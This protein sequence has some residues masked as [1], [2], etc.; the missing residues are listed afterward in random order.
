M[1]CNCGYVDYHIPSCPQWRQIPQS[2][3]STTYT[4]TQCPDFDP[5]EEKITSDCV[6][7]MGEDLECFGIYNGDSATTIIGHILE[8]LLPNCTTTSTTTSTTTTTTIDPA[9][10]HCITFTNVCNYNTNGTGARYT[11]CNGV[12]QVIKDGPGLNMVP[13]ETITVCGSNPQVGNSC[14]AFYVEG[15]PCDL[16]P[17]GVYFCGTLPTT[18]TSTSTTT[19]APCLCYTYA[20]ANIDPKASHTFTYLSCSTKIQTA[21][22]LSAAGTIGDKVSVCVCNEDISAPKGFFTVTPIGKDCITSTST[23]TTTTAAVTPTPC[24]NYTIIAP[25]NTAGTYSYV[26]CLLNITITGEITNNNPGAVDCVYIRAAVAGSVFV[27]VGSGLV[28][29]PG[30][31]CPT[32]TTTTPVCATFSLFNTDTNS[33]TYAYLDCVGGDVSGTLAAGQCISFRALTGSITYEVGIQFFN[34]NVCPTT[35]TTSTSTTTT[36]LALTP[37]FLS[38]MTAT[39][40]FSSILMGVGELG[41]P[42]AYPVP[43]NVLLTSYYT[44]TY[45]IKVTLTNVQAGTTIKVTD[46]NG[47]IQSYTFA[48]SGG[49]LY[50]TFNGVVLNGIT[51]MKIEISI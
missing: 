9:L 23:T 39:S 16:K 3:T 19:E 47:I 14:F 10:C 44:G 29:A 25:G 6:V 50:R 1:S 35:T 18:T 40:N 30:D 45:N 32:T 2:T 41:N 43:D 36:T 4:T 26:D 17:G 38:N 51:Q 46:S 49:G 27:Q 24:S 15:A 13:G 34:G 22:T 37:V 7:Y 21:L 33:H 28:I 20:V 5:C 8:Q 31:A 42:L 12:E 48:V 11:D